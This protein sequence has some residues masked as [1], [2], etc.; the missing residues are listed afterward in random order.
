MMRI[1]QV[2]K[3]SG[4]GFGTVRKA[5]ATEVKISGLKRNEGSVCLGTWRQEVLSDDEETWIWSLECIGT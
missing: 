1:F 2:S 5:T 4:P 3:I